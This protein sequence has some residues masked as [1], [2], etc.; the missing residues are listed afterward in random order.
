MQKIRSCIRAAQI[1]SADEGTN[2]SLPPFHPHIQ[3]TRPIIPASIDLS[4]PLPET[5]K[6]QTALNERKRLSRSVQKH[7]L[8][9]KISAAHRLAHRFGGMIALHWLEEHPILHLI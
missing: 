6:V 9:A 1:P 2:F 5:V 3:Q 7:F 4:M 8:P